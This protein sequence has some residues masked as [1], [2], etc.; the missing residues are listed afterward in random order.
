[1]ADGQLAR[2]L[3]WAPLKL[4]QQTNLLMHPHRQCTGIATILCLIGRLLASL[5][6]AVAPRAAV[7]THLPVDGGLVPV[8]QFGNL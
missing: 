6:G 5:F 2:N 1:M 4:K 3:L 7:A 8:Q